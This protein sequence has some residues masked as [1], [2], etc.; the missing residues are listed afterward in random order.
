MT[1]LAQ[2]TFCLE[3]TSNPKYFM[4]KA[5]IPLTER[6]LDKYVE[7]ESEAAREEVRDDSSREIEDLSD[8]NSELRE[9]ISA[10]I[11]DNPMSPLKIY[12]FSDYETPSHFP[13][14]RLRDTV[15]N[16][17]IIKF[18]D[19]VWHD[20]KALPSPK[21]SAKHLNLQTSEVRKYYSKLRSKGLIKKNKYGSWVWGRV[22]AFL[23][24][25]RT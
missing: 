20:E 19:E 23:E 7:E 10:L 12:L 25:I 22:E 11:S 16:L 5:G 9:S 1:D 3:M 13:V 2:E 14:I 4:E 17:K 18:M 8:D 24:P 21:A 15:E 6:A